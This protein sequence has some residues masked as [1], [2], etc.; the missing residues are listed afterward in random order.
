MVFFGLEPRKTSINTYQHRVGHLLPISPLDI[1]CA[2]G[3]QCSRAEILNETRVTFISISW[4]LEYIIKLGF[5]WHYE[6]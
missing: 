3:D 4:N 1:T 2:S 6:T 5:Y